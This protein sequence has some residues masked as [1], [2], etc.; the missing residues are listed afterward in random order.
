MQWTG[1]WCGVEEC[2]SGRGRQRESETETHRQTERQTGKQADRQTDTETKRDTHTHNPE[3]H[4][5]NK[6][7]RAKKRDK[8]VYF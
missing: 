2:T 7:G 8:K 5:R 3:T 1:A 4:T 6:Y